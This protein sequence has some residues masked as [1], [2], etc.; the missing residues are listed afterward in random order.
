MW[1]MLGS[2]PGGLGSGSGEL[3]LRARMSRLANH[4][5]PVFKGALM[6]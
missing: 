2:R 6:S 1:W 3:K 4:V 5:H